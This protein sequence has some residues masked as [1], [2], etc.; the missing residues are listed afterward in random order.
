MEENTPYVFSQ[1]T[2]VIQPKKSWWQVGLVFCIFVAIIVFVSVYFINPPTSFP[3]GYFLKVRSGDNLFSVSI[4][5]EEAH[6][7]KNARVLQIATIISGGER[8][9]RTGDYYFDTPVNVLEVARRISVGDFNIIP[10]KLTIPEGFTTVDIANRIHELLPNISTSEFITRAKGS[11]G[12]LFP[13]TY[14]ISPVAT[15]DEIYSIFIE[16]YTSEIQKIKKDI[17]SSG[18]TENQ[19]I[20][21]ASLIEREAF[22]DVDR[23]MISGIL[24]N[25]FD[26]GMRLQVDAPFYYLLGKG[27]ADLT[28]ADLKIDS[29]YN[30]YV[31]AGLPPTPIGSP[32]SA[33]IIASLNP[34]KSE[35][36]FYLHDKNGV[37]HYAKTF[38]EH[39]KNIRVYLK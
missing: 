36:L 10:V 25:R 9:I 4:K 3:A 6:L 27:S 31:Y 20:T 16:R 12:K 32:G 35:Y 2:L 29:P 33:S 21:M 37:A 18:R 14:F 11:E 38:S 8:S 28:K 5:A 17:A 34:E 30:T 24:W 13:D 22:G 15:V 23:S 26:S 1:E 7:V 39:Q 19:I